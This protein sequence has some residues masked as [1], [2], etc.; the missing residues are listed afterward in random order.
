MNER[1]KARF[2]TRRSVWVAKLTEEEN[3]LQNDEFLFFMM[4]KLCLLGLNSSAMMNPDYF[5]NIQLISL[6][7][8]KNFK[9]TGRVM[10]TVLV[11]CKL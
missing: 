11:G 8:E 2:S 3:K 4:L 9:L 5:L 7:L 6:P 10:K 1:I